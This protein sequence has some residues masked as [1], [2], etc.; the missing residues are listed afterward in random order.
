MLK[1]HL[2]SYVKRQDDNLLIGNS[3]I[4]RRWKLE[5]GNMISD[6]VVNKKTGKVWENKPLTMFGKASDIVFDDIDLQIEEDGFI[7]VKVLF[8][9]KNFVRAYL[10]VEIRPNSSFIKTQLYRRSFKVEEESS[11]EES[12]E[13]SGIEKVNDSLPDLPFDAIDTIPYSDKHVEATCY[14]FQDMTDRHNNLI[15]KTQEYLYYKPGARLVTYEGNI[16]VLDAYLEKEKLMLIK[17]GPT[18]YGGLNRRE[19]DFHIVPGEYISLVGSGFIHD[20]QEFNGWIPSYGATIGVSDGDITEAYKKYY[21]ALM[22]KTDLF[23]MSNTWGDRNQDKCINESFVKKEID[24]AS[25]LGLDLVQIDDGWQEG[26]T[27]NSAIQSGGVWEGYY[28]HRSDF[29]KVNHDKFPHGLASLVDYASSK[30]IELALWFSPDSSNDFANWQKDLKTVLDLYKKYGIKY[31]KLDGIKIRSK[32]GEYNFISFLEMVKLKSQNDIVF[33]MDITAEKRFG[34]LYEKE[35]ATL[36]VE[37]RY[38]DWGSYYP[39][40]T[41]RNIWVLSELIPS[42]RLQMEL[43]NNKRNISHYEDPL[44]PDKYDM[45]YLFA[46]TMVT[47]PLFWMELSSLES[48]DIELLKDTIDKYKR[49]R[50]KFQGANIKPIGDMP[51]GISYTGFD[52]Q[53]D[54]DSGYLLVFREMHDQ[55]SFNYHL[56]NLASKDI[57]LRSLIGE[58]VFMNQVKSIDTCGR[59]EIS[60]KTTRSYSLIEYKTLDR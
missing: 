34:Y 17:D 19:N 55:E 35:H 27:A 51:N 7:S 58:E 54:D 43:L 29:W 26:I 22:Q 48:Q 40:Y 3:L 4:E 20:N 30:K 44:S 32:L 9:M 37:N 59:L 47:N 38:T 36:F 28:S 13:V 46:V 57:L 33:N 6:L 11:L 60:L 8:K 1:K 15:Q 16:M 18:Q 52:I 39:H 50:H 42:Q 23:M 5:N 2:D 12:Q 14:R 24:V 53:V 41:L 25:D 56:E 10:Q 31:F 21:H 49:V 45:D